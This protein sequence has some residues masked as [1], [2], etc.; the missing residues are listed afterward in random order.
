MVRVSS[1][2]SM[3]HKIASLEDEINYMNSVYDKINVVSLLAQ[4]GLF[5]IMTEKK[6]LISFNNILTAVINFST[7]KRLAIP[8]VIKFITLLHGNP[9]SSASGEQSFSTALCIKT[10]KKKHG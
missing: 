3:T 2:D 7:H 10:L 9:C 6:K 1:V 4:L 8:E 5:R